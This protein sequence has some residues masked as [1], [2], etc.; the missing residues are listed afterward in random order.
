M[1]IPGI[2]ETC[3]FL[4]RFKKCLFIT[5]SNR[6]VHDDVDTERESYIKKIKLETSFYNIFR[7]TIRILINDYE[8][9]KFIIASISNQYYNFNFT[10]NINLNKY[11]KVK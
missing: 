7:N 11:I 3:A 4:D 10:G 8:N 2:E 1:V 6:V 9:I 5:T